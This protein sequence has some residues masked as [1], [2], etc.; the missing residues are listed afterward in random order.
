MLSLLG[1][2]VNQRVLVSL[3][4]ILGKS[5]PLECDLVAC[6]ASGLWLSGPDLTKQV[7]PGHSH[8][9]PIPVF[10]PYSQVAFLYA[11]VVRRPTGPPGGQAAD[12]PAGHAHSPAKPHSPKRNARTKRR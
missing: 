4:S 3:P 6:E 12:P 11:V 1:Q 8:E 7:G 5:E 2:Q 10:V 9:A